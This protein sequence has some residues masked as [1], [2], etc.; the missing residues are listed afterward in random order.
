MMWSND[1]HYCTVEW[2][3][4]IDYLALKDKKIKYF[5]IGL[6]STLIGS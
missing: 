1:R 4:K 3:P 5:S 6:K 2:L